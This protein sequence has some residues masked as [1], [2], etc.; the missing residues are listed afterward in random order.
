M[1]I[2]QLSNNQSSY[3][4]TTVNSLA[5]NKN[6]GLRKAGYTGQQMK[7]LPERVC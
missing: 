6:Y 5:A 3:V 4:C 1:S 7:Q 2:L